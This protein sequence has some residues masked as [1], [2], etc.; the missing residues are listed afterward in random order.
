MASIV[1]AISF[2]GSI[3]RS[4][5]TTA[6]IQ[7]RVLESRTVSGVTRRRDKGSFFLTTT[8]SPYIIESEGVA[9]KGMHSPGAGRIDGVSG[10]GRGLVV[11][12]VG[13]A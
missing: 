2:T 3:F 5:R 11:V 1:V 4:L 6:V 10:V 7:G 9:I 8:C 12:T 13:I